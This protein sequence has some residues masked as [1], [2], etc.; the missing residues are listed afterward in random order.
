MIVRFEPHVFLRLYAAKI[1]GTSR[2]SKKDRIN[3][4]KTVLL[5]GMEMKPGIRKDSKGSYGVTAV[6]NI[7]VSAK[8]GF[9]R[10]LIRRNAPTL[11][12]RV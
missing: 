11:N 12:A 5:P 1:L 7:Y 9:K 3:V 2:T 10:F 4:G 8:D 6:S